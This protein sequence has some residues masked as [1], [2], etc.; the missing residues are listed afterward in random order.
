MTVA[1][2]ASLILLVVVILFSVFLGASKRLFLGERISADST[3]EAIRP[4]D[5]PNA[6][7]NFRELVRLAN[8]FGDIPSTL[9]EFQ[10][11][12]VFSR[13]RLAMSRR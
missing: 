7:S 5:L 6:S 10:F 2:Y 3:L 12:Y 4:F 9:V 8:F 1:A 11:G 13:V